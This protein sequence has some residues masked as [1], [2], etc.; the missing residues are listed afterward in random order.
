[1]QKY[2]KVIVAAI[3]AV[4]LLMLG[5]CIKGGIDN[6]TNKDRQPVCGAQSFDHQQDCGSRAGRVLHRRGR[7]SLQE[8]SACG[9]NHHLFT[10][11]LNRKTASDVS[12]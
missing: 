10:Q 3:L 11:R 8:E 9:V 1:M 12:L 6:F 2:E 7:H 5:L 4:G